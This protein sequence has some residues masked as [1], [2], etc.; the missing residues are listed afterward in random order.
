MDRMRE[1]R[2]KKKKLRGREG[3]H[4]SRQTEKRKK[5]NPTQRPYLSSIN[6][7]GKL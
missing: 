3:E 5:E 7:G 2:G 4:G 6:N 1:N